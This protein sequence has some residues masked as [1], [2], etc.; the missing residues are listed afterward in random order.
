MKQDKFVAGYQAHESKREFFIAKKSVSL[1]IVLVIC[2]CFANSLAAGGYI[3]YNV[4]SY[5]YSAANELYDII[6]PAC[7]IPW[8]TGMWRM[9]AIIW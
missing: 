1:V 3:T 2:L 4:E 8:I 7:A 6:S 9:P 5:D